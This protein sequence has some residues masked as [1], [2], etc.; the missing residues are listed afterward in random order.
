MDFETAKTT[1]YDNLRAHGCPESIAK[2]ALAGATY[3]EAF[4]RSAEIAKVYL[5]HARATMSG[6]FYAQP[7]PA[8]APTAKP[9]T[10]NWYQE[11]KRKALQIREQIFK[12][13][14]A[15]RV[16]EQT[17]EVTP[18]F[19]NEGEKVALLDAQLRARADEIGR[20]I[21]ADNARM[22]LEDLGL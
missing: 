20:R 12:Q 18:V 19:L 13:A 2:R 14:D 22:E 1:I 5:R 15:F 11:A 3:T 17:L 16:N 6:V 21:F 9:S 8:P 7:S 10:D 4:V